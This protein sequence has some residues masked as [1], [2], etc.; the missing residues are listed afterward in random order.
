MSI[1]RPFNGASLRKP[2]AYS[3]T[4]VNLSG[5]FPLAATG[6]V[7]IIG[8][9]NGGAP[10]SSAGVQ[11]YTSEDIAALIA[12][13]QSGP[14]V[15]AAR[16]LVAPARDRRVPNGASQ[17]KVYKV[18]PSTRSSLNLRNAAPVNLMLLSSANFGESENLIQVKV[19]AGLNA[20]ARII[21]VKKG[22]VTEVLSENAFDA[23]MAI[24]Y[25]GADAACTL[26]V[27]LVSGVKTLVLK[28]GSTPADDLNVQL[29]NKTMQD[30]VDIVHN[31]G[32]TA[33]AKYSATST[34]AKRS[35]TSSASL[36][37]VS[38]ATSIKASALTLR[39]QQQELAD[40]INSESSLITAAV[41]S[42]VE[43]TIAT[44]GT[45][46]FLTGA[47]KGASAN[48]DF[49]TGFDALLAHRCN[50]VVPLI[51]RDAS[52]LA[53]DGLTE[54]A[55]AFT[56][57]AVN[58]QA[59]THCITASNTKNRSERNCYVSKKASFA[60][61]QTAAKDLN[62][63]RASMLFQDV[64]I[65]KADGSLSF[66][67]PW[68]AACML[69]GMQA[70]MEVGT[71]ATHKGLNCNGIRHAD[72]NTKTQFDLAIDAGLLPL[73]ERDSGGFRVVVHNSTYSN[74][75]NFVYNRPSVLAAADYVAYNMRQ[76]LEAIFVGEKARTGS[77]QAIK[78][79]IVSIM[80]AFLNSEII[81]GDDTNDK[82]GYKDLLVTV[83]GNTAFVDVTITPV[84][85]ID[86]VLN[87]IT[88]DDIRQ[89]A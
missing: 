26:E 18:N 78:N 27:K 10:G 52:A 65:S 74:D 42:Q 2:G 48:S 88:L 85:G 19:A 8:E 79:T 46:K 75:A 11:T 73:E 63:E 1:I 83:N 77:A 72:Y 23:C 16:A 68:A 28:T 9:A 40:I 87:R 64:E 51:S 4:S 5:G 76:Q 41:L 32:G 60:D 58:L 22:T 30:V 62:H 33:G 70:G 14:I 36:D 49:Q 35:S 25:T 34:F 7:A 56:V 20:S 69:A 29:V 59:V 89:S 86:F 67:E 71:P 37:W 57:D 47:V 80:T 17:I 3:Q 84:Q 44:F 45:F 43:G 54:P 24:Q 15:D 38:T 81:V 21:T 13:Y 55:S 61:A 53:A 66:E 6:V 31:F 82:L 12:E 39:K 50:I